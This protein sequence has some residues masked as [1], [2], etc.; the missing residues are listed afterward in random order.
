MA[1]AACKS[2][3]TQDV[4]LVE[5]RLA[6]V[7]GT[8]LQPQHIAAIQ[9]LV[10]PTPSAEAAEAL[11]IDAALAHVAANR[12]LSSS[13]IGEWLVSYRELHSQ[14]AQAANGGRPIDHVIARLKQAK[15]EHGFRAGTC[16]RKEG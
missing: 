14:S 1:V 12:S 6:V 9:A 4:D 11:A 16:A 7:A 5:C 3:V 15:S 8:H 10:Q 13:E 2:D